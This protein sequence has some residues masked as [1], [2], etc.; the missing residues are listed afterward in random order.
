MADLKTQ[1]KNNVAVK[2][3][4]IK[5]LYEVIKKEKEQY[6]VFEQTARPKIAEAAQVRIPCFRSPS[7]Y[8]Y[9]SS[10]TV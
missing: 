7:N 8:V 4:E 5:H 2:D 6:D 10:K 9:F 1:L 3:A